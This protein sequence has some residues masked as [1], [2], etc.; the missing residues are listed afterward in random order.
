MV[1]Y[2]KKVRLLY[3]NGRE[4]VLECDSFEDFG[5][6]AVYKKGFDERLWNMSQILKWEFI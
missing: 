6:W 5:H 1:I 2:M 3:I 4:N